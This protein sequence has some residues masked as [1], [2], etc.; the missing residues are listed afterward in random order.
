MLIT[1]NFLIFSLFPFDKSIIKTFSFVVQYRYINKG[2]VFMFFVFR[3]IKENIRTKNLGE[4]FMWL[5][6]IMIGVR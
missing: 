3:K 6:K 2:G 1:F 5:I 4:G